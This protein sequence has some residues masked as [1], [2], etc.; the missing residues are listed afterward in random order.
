MYKIQKVWVAVHVTRPTL[1]ASRIAHP[2]RNEQRRS[3]HRDM[4][5][6]IMLS[7]A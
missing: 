2:S 6:A 5:T 7:Q 3:P 1:Q 4:R